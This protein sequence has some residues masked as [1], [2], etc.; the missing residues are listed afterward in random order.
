ML[1][2]A[3]PQGLTGAEG[4]VHLDELRPGDTTASAH[5]M[6]AG[7]LPPHDASYHRPDRVAQARA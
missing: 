4:A 3:R 5:G 6:I 1:T 7:R 2:G